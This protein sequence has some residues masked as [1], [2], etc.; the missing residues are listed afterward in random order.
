MD[1]RLRRWRLWF[2]ALM[3]ATPLS[4]YNLRKYKMTAF[5][6]FSLVMRLELNHSHPQ[7]AFCYILPKTSRHFTGQRRAAR[8]K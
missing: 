4:K 2:L 7:R 8:G 5:S 3:T 1:W 6:S